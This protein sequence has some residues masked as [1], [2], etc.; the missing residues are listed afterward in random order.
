[1]D[2]VFHT[3]YGHCGY[4]CGPPIQRTWVS[5]LTMIIVVAIVA[6]PFSGHGVPHGLWSLLLPLWPTPTAD[7][8]FHIDYGHCCCHC[9]SPLQWTRYSTL[10]KIIV[11]AIVAHPFRGHVV[12]HCLWSLLL[13]LWPTPTVDP[14]FYIDYGHCCCHCGPPLQRTLF[15]N[16]TMIIVVAIVAHLYSGQIF[17]HELYSLLLPLCP[18]PT[19]DTMFH[20]EYGHCCCHCGP[21]LQWTRC[22][23]LTNVIVVAIVA[24]PYS[25]QDVPH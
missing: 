11:A 15:S 22:S 19:A 3:D 12:Q 2:P 20:N 8:V 7:T 21:P 23:T 1:M 14:V 17:P 25:G 10:T 9:G 18:T 13:P 16:W 5:T 4:H 6:Q 24:Y